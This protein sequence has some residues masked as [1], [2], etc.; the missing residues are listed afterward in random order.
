[1][2]DTAVPKGFGF[3]S[4]KVGPLPLWMWITAGIGVWFFLMRKP[5]GA[6]SP[7]ATQSQ[8]GYGTDPAGNTGYIDPQSGYVYGSAE[9]IASLQQQGQVAGNM[10]AGQDQAK[11]PTGGY[12][13]NTAW[14]V[15]AINYLVAQGVDPT[16][17]TQSIQQY[18]AGQTL[19]TQQQAQV[20]LAVHALGA[21]PSPPGPS[22]TQPG[23][24]VPPPT[25]GKPPPVTV[26]PPTHLQVDKYPAPSGLHVVST[27]PTTA[28]VM[29]NN[30]TSP[31]PAPHNYTVA[32]YQLNGK[33]VGYSTVSPDATGN[34]THYT[35]PGLHTRWQYKIDVWANGGKQAPPHA[36][37]VATC[38]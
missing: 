37:V 28:E 17:A 38:K 16:Q 21:P 31:K 3:L 34:T 36:E 27:T 2:P 32:T 33:R 19:T 7:A 9:D 23:Q 30:L 22:G 15:A 1:M 14:S 29:W 11:T 4:D 13:D 6:Q 10:F 24:V 8:T 20:N 25:D 5:S 35:V 12:A 18:L 26:P